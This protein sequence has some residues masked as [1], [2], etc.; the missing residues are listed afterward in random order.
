MAHKDVESSGKPTNGLQTDC[1]RLASTSR[2]LE[3]KS[4]I[5]NV[6][7]SIEAEVKRL[8]AAVSKAVQERDEFVRCV[9]RQL[10]TRTGKRRTMSAAGRKRISEAAKARWATA[11]KAGAK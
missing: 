4:A 7:K 6:F 5:M 10:G 8:D 1:S 9:S 2:N 11:K 3:R